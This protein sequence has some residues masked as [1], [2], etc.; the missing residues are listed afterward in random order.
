MFIENNIGDRAVAELM[1]ARGYARVEG[2]GVDEVFIR[3]EKAA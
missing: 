3:D 2:L 1:R